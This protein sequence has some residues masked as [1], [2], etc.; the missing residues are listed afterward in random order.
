M[1]A[2]QHDAPGTLWIR[3]LHHRINIG[4]FGGLGNPPAGRL[5]KTVELDFQASAA[6]ASIAFE[7]RLDPFPRRADATSRRDRSWILCGKGRASLEAHQLL[8]VGLNPWRGNLPQG[9]R[10]LRVRWACW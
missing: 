7:F 2:D 5:S 6:V 8:N 4:D 3:S 1:T 10:D 9:C